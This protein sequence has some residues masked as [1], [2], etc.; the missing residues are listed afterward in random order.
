MKIFTAILLCLALLL[1]ACGTVTEQPELYGYYVGSTIDAE[2]YEISMDSVY[3]GENYILLAAEG[4]GE[5]C[6]AGNTYDIRWKMKGEE[7]RLTLEGKTSKGYIEAGRIRL[8]YLDMGMELHYDFY[9]DYT[10]G[11]LR[12]LTEEQLWWHGDWYGWWIVDEAQGSF[13]DMQGA[14][15]DLCATVEMQGDGLGTMRLWDQDG[16]KEEPLGEVRFRLNEDGV[17]VSTQG[18]FASVQLGQGDWLMDPQESGMEDMLLLSFGGENDGGSFYYSI[19]L[20]PWGVD[21]QE[22]ADKP[23]HYDS[24]YLPLIAEGKPMPHSLPQTP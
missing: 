12:E 7:L 16:S 8:D 22:L 20:R 6:L 5:M 14:W 10:P 21:W 17:G 4:K 15:W 9:E 19:Y 24:W 1:G 11:A 18:Y 2:G 3:A 13:Q 23:Y